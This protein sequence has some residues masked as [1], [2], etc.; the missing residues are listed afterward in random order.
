MRIASDVIEDWLERIAVEGRNLTKWEHEFIE[1]VQDQF[2][3]SGSLSDKQVD[4][5]ERIYTERVP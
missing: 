3:R 1:S 5:V 4:V 2:D